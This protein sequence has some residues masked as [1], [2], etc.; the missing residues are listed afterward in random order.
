M[1]YILD[2]LKKSSEERRRLQAEDEQRRT[3][4]LNSPV[5]Q[6]APGPYRW[7]IVLLLVSVLVFSAVGL[8]YLSN[9][10]KSDSNVSHPEATLPSDRQQS[11]ELNATDGPKSVS[12]ET[13]APIT[14]EQTVVAP[15]RKDTAAGKSLEEPFNANSEPKLPLM[16]E[17]P[18]AIQSQLPEMKFSGHVFSPNPELRMIMINT[19]VVREGDLIDADLRLM[20]ITRDGLTMSHQGK[21]FKVVLF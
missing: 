13:V 9:V 1:S 2:A 14:T 6:E 12:S 11:L 19:S 4:P 8:W 18:L 21:N 15:E 7:L 5:K 16:E 20:E 17:L 10:Y 3:L